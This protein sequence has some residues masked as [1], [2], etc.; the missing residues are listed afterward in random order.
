MTRPCARKE[1]P[2]LGCDGTLGV[3]QDRVENGRGHHA[4]LMRC[5]ECGEKVVRG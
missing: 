1:C 3:V 2:S 4:T 5:G